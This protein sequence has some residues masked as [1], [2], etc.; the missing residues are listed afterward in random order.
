MWNIFSRGKS[1]DPKAKAKRIFAETG[2]LPKLIR[3]LKLNPTLDVNK[4]RFD[5]G[6]T[7]L[8]L[9][10]SSD[11]LPVASYLIEHCH[12]DIDDIS[13]SGKTALHISCELE[14]I[15]AVKFLL[16][17]GAKIDIKDAVG[18]IALS[19]CNA[20]DIQQVLLE[21]GEVPMDDDIDDKNY[22]R[23]DEIQQAVVKHI[24]FETGSVKDLHNLLYE[25]PKIDLTKMKF[26]S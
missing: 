8:Q 24:C 21:A 18:K 19:Y 7:S 9:S 16:K 17:H 23:C 20:L 5:G 13:N 25:N 3:L 10:L 12:V 15:D 11:F 14:K 2:N 4:L 6:L 26:V 22:A 1:S